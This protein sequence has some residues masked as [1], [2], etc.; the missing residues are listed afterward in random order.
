MEYA[1]NRESDYAEVLTYDGKW[2]GTTLLR[3]SILCQPQHWN[4]KPRRVFVCSM[5]DLF[6][7]GVTFEVQRK[8]FDAIRCAPKM[9]TFMVLTK[10]PHWLKWFMD[11]MITKEDFWWKDNGEN[12][13]FGVS[14]ENQEQA[15][16]RIP[17]LLECPCQ[18][19]NLFVSYEPAIGPVDFSP[20]ISNLG[21]LVMGCE[22]GPNHRPMETSWVRDVRDLCVANRVPFMFKQ[23]YEGNKLIRLPVLDGAVWDGQ[24]R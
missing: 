20:W 9:H 10:R 23:A 16:K 17:L 2:A 6:Y 5:S 3:E 21:W 13:F 19:S 14:A 7:E 18:P 4:K 15:D 24:P 22:S 11:R 8:V 12:L 1:R